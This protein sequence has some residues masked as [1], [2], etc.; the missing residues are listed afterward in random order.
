[1]G[2]LLITAIDQPNYTVMANQLNRPHKWF[3]VWGGGWDDCV[4]VVFRN[5]T[6]EMAPVLPEDKQNQ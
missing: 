5:V 2:L 3:L 1:M 6:M 4:P